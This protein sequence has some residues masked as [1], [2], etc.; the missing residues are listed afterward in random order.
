[1]ELE[2]IE[3]WKEKGTGSKEKRG[4]RK[5]GGKEGKYHAFLKKE[6]KHK[7]KELKLEQEIGTLPV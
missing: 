6:A 7:M 1:M 2:G 4:R 3:V 5:E